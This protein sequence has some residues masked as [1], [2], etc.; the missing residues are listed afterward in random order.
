MA[1]RSKNNQV[2]IGK[3]NTNAGSKGA[4]VLPWP[5]WFSRDWLLGLILVLA[6]ILVYQPV[7]YAGFIWD[8]DSLIITNPCMIGPFGL[9][10]IWT[11]N[12]ADICPLTLSTFWAEHALWGLAPLPYHLLNVLWHGACAVLLWRILR[13]LQV[14]GAW[15]GAVLWALH[16]VQVESV[17][18]IS[19]MKNTESGLFFLLSILFFVRWL[20]AKD[21]DRQTDARVC[22][23]IGQGRVASR[24][25]AAPRREEGE[26]PL[27]SLTDEQQRC[28]P[29]VPPPFGPGFFCLLAS[30]LTPYRPLRVCSSLDAS[31]EG[32]SSP[33]ATLS[34]SITHPNWNYGLTLLF[35]ALAMA[36]KSST[37]ILPMVLCLCAWW[38]EGKWHWRNLARVFPIFIISIAASAL[39]IWTQGL[40]LKTLTDPQW[41][42]TWPQRLM[43]A[44]DAVWFYLGKLLWPHPLMTAYPRWQI[45]AGWWFWYVPLLAVIIVLLI[46]WLKRGT[47][48][49]PWFFTFAYFLTA[50]FPVLGL[51]DNPIFRYS[52]VFDHFQYL[53][54]MGPLA[55]AGAGLV[56]LMDFVIPGKPWLQ[57]ALCAG[58]LLILGMMS[59]HRAWAYQS[60]ETLWTDELAKNPDSWLGYYGLGVA[61][62]TKGQVDEAMAQ[63][64]KALEIDPNSFEA[65]DNLGIA[66]AQEGRVDEAMVQF[67]KTLKID[68]NFAEAYRNLGTAL[69]TKGQ[70]NEAMAQFQK[71]LEI[72]PN[73]VEAHDNL[74][75]ALAQEGRVDEAMAQF[76]KS[77]EIDPNSVEAHDNLGIALAQEGRVDE[78]MVQ[79]QKSLEIDPNFAEAYCNLGIALVQK[80][81]LD[82]AM[83][84][85]Q[86]AL[87]ID[88]NFA[89]VYNSLGDVLVQMGQVNEAKVQYQ[90]ALEID[91]N[92]VLAQHNLA[93]IQAMA[94]QA[95]GAK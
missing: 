86:Q 19:E 56:R 87:E 46:L 61:L 83:A 18:W 63:Y 79:F 16:P 69:V 28:S 8:D 36:C 52:L 95:P 39:S 72:D 50:L 78:A 73:S 3:D 33:G 11:T 23:R 60:E 21:L 17:A 82:E 81:R 27:R 47:W 70:M 64:Q 14:P 25:W 41:V 88:P 45:D 43:G 58:L 42:R 7:W 53:A 22:Y 12:A 94:P 48:S 77:L 15:L 38:M 32:K 29:K 1:K 85:F 30:L 40:V 68:P 91:P 89:E 65:H 37:V 84:Q 66:L 49:R 2:V 74:G 80:G 62:V 92:Y 75:I 54:D 44:G 55:L 59:W 5:S 31:P 90:K 71:S 9:K 57:S 13:S 6:V 24:F 34:Y 67:Q 26:Y 35:A 4:T 93:K 20:R 51:V 76:Q 10:E